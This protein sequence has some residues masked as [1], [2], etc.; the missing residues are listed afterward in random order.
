[1]TVAL[2]IG[3]AIFVFV[4]VLSLLNRLVTR[5]QAEQMARLW[6]ERERWRD[7]NSKPRSDR[8]RRSRPDSDT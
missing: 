5:L 2:L 6:N 3:L 4:I 7:P 8:G 1:M